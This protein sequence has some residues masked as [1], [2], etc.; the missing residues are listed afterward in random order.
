MV[1][2]TTQYHLE[3]FCIVEVVVPGKS[4]SRVPGIFSI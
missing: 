4:I 1:W 2:E 3:G